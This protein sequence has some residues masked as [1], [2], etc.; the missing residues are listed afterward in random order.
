MNDPMVSVLI[1][2]YGVEL[3]IERC[4]RSLMEQTLDNIEYIF[5]DDCSPDN[6]IDILNSV[7][8]EYPHRIP[9]TRIIHHEKNRGLAAAR[10]SGIKCAT[11]EYLIHCDSDDW[12]EPNMYELLYKKAKEED[13]EV[14]VCDFWDEFGNKSVRVDVN[15]RISPAR[16]INER[17]VGYYWFVWNKLVKRDLISKNSLYQIEGINMW[18]DIVVTIPLFALTDKISFLSDPLYHYNRANENSI[19]HNKDIKVK[20]LQLKRAVDYIQDYLQATIYF[21]EFFLK[22]FYL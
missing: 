17:N 18:E 11:G 8:N 6:S 14:V 4:V 1:P 5:V 15:P 9:Q 21:E 7:L 20:G 13:A 10:L 19:I 2:I 12:V 3:Y 22:I 16:I